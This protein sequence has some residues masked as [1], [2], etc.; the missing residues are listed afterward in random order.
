MDP[1]GHTTC[2]FGIHA[3]NLPHTL[4]DLLNPRAVSELKLAH[5]QIDINPFLSLI[6]SYVIL[7]AAE[8][9]L[10]SLKDR[11]KK[12]KKVL[13]FQGEADKFFDYVVIDCPPNLGLLTFNALEAA[14]EIIIP[15]EPSFFSLH[16]LAK[17]SE[18]ITFLNQK[19]V[20][21][22]EI[23]AL[24][25]LFDS[26]TCFARDVYEEV[27]KHFQ[28]RLFKTMIHEDVALKEAAGAGKSIDQYNR[29]SQAFKDYSSL[30]MEYLERDWNRRLPREHL[31]WDNIVRRHYRPKKAVGGILFQ[32]T[33]GNAQIVEIA[34]DFNGWIPESMASRE[35]GKLWQLVIPMKHG[36]YRYK[37]IVDGEWQ[38]DA[39]HGDRRPN[40]Y[41]SYD[42]LVEVSL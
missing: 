34:G 23:H 6:P 9:E 31:G 38:L 18:T 7:S 27:K 21:P 12:L 24:L 30:A 14:D 20:V 28:K 32:T 13:D 42:S 5:V 16:G 19:R 1:Q 35:S 2:G 8:E 10:A 17:M 22:L 29:E 25:T 26:R 39:S 11:E 41:G 3:E 36:Q 33:A 15:I 37:F 40:V 4:Y